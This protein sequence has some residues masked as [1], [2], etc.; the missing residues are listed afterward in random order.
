MAMAKL[1]FHPNAYLSETRNVKQGL[2]SRSRILRVL[3]R[4]IS[5]AM[6]IARSSQLSYGVVIHHLRLLERE[7]IVLRKRK[8]KPYAWQLSGRGQQRL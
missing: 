4:R 3:E 8:K 6:D 5:T 2:A 1:A 7:G